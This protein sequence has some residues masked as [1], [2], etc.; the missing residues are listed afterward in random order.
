[1]SEDLGGRAVQDATAHFH[2]TGHPVIE[3][4]EPGE[5]ALVLRRPAEH[6]AVSEFTAGKL[7][8]GP[9]LV[10][11]QSNGGVCRDHSLPHERTSSCYLAGSLHFS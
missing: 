2:S 11:D 3:S 8:R 1:M 7:L 4:L 9:K 5:L 6:D 10:N